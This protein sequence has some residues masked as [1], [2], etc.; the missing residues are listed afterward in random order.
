MA[1]SN[2]TLSEWQRMSVE[3][4]QR[5]CQSLAQRLP[6]ELRFEGLE[7]H[8]YCGREHRVARFAGTGPDRDI[9]FALVPGGEVSL[10][11]DGESFKPSPGQ[12]ESYAQ[13]VEKY[14]IGPI[15]AFVDTQI[16][17]PRTAQLPTLLIEIEAREVGTEPIAADDPA[18]ADLVHQLRAQKQRKCDAGRYFVARDTSDVIHAWRRRKTSLVDLEAGLTASGLRLLTCDEWEYA[19]GAGAPTLFRWGNDCPTDCYP[20]W[21]RSSEQFHNARSPAVPDVYQSSNLFG[22][23]IARNPYELDLVADGPRV[24]GGDGGR[25]LCSGVGFFLGWLPLA[26]AFRE[27]DPSGAINFDD[28]ANGF[29]RIRRAIPLP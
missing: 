12:I 25:N 13:S 24:L 26:T 18:V 6:H 4:A 21:V 9:T 10:G 23:T 22:L 29:C 15:G 5:E 3:Q 11:F 28:V 16:S 1:L 19:C 2:L 14:G 20:N 7:P 17:Q 27:S 8:R